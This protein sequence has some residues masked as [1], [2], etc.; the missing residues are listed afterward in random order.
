[1]I[2]NYGEIL[3]NTIFEEQNQIINNNELINNVSI[4]EVD[5][6]TNQIIWFS[7]DI[8]SILGKSIAEVNLSMNIIFDLAL[9]SDKKELKQKFKLLLDNNNKIDHLFKIRRYNDQK[10]RH[11]YLN[12]EIKK[13]R[14]NKPAIIMILLIDIT[15]H[16]TLSVQNK[17]ADYM[18]RTLY[19]KSPFGIALIDSFTG[20]IYKANEKYQELVSIKFDDDSK[21]DWMSFTHPEDIKLDLDNMEKMNKN[22]ID[23]YTMDKRYIKSDGSLIWVK[24]TI[25]PIIIENEKLDKHLCIIENITEKKEHLEKIKYSL[26]HDLLTGLYNR[27]YI[28]NE[29]DKLKAEG[30]FPI[31]IILGNINGIKTYNEIFGHQQGDQEIIRIGNKIKEFINISGKVARVGGDEYIILLSEHDENSIREFTVNLTDYVNYSDQDL[32]NTALSISFGFAQQNAINDT[33]DDLYKEAEIFLYSK[34]YY[35]KRSTRSNTINLIMNTLFE[36]SERERNH[37][38]RVGEISNRIAK[39][40]ELDEEKIDKVRIAGYL[41]DIG[42]IGIDESILNKKGKLTEAEWETIKLHTIKG[43]RILERSKEYKHIYNIVL[44][45]H[46]RYDGKGYPNALSGKDIPLEARIITLADAYDAMT[47]DRPYKN[48]MNHE[49]ALKEIEKC[50]GSHFD[51]DI[52][53][54]FIKNFSN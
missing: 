36:K 18:F 38:H 24:M 23:G 46:E 13:D 31:S 39:L 45:H 27:D 12:A 6:F 54:V 14:F 49:A 9:D 19:N 22:Q 30:I 26:E 29:Y 37:S 28:K 3:H 51:P 33:M 42:K 17:I 16:K 8:P 41:H 15:D 47:K 48:T 43:A 32:K 11:I 7:E 20:K 34:K 35:N 44:S 2:D 53:E 50:A 52:V 40:M 1:M 21:I 25:I 5:I 4:I 10:I